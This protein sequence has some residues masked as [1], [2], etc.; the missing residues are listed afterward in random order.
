MN[1]DRITG[2][3]TRIACPARLAGP[4]IFLLTLLL[5]PLQGLA[6]EKLESASAE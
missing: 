1:V 4:G 5:F 2:R 6:G 3:L